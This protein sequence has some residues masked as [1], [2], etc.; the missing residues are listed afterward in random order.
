MCARNYKIQRN[1]RETTRVRK[2]FS[3]CSKLK[4]PW[5]QFIIPGQSPGYH[6]LM[7]CA[8]YLARI[9]CKGRNSWLWWLFLNS[10]K[11]KWIA[12]STFSSVNWWQVWW[13]ECQGI[14]RL[15]P[16]SWDRVFLERT[17]GKDTDAWRWREFNGF[18]TLWRLFGVAWCGSI[19]L[20]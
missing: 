8:M 20:S 11:T 6:H 16:A 10:C 13:N 14:S 15:L 18:W 1:P 2:A 19:C 4:A 7:I 3:K 5:I 9:L 17:L 12:D